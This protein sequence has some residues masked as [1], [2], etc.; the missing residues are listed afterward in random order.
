MTLLRWPERAMT[1]RR[2]RKR[3]E[4]KCFIHWVG[5]LRTDLRVSG[6]TVYMGPANY[7]LLK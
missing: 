3:V 6:L 7:K 4:E 2:V 1:A 5:C